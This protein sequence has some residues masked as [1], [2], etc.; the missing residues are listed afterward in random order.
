MI[1]VTINAVDKSDEIDQ[2]SL[3]YQGAVTKDPSTLSFVI[4]KVPGR[5]LPALG[6]VVIASEDGDRFFKGTIVERDDAV[7]SGLLIGTKF[8]CK[9]GIHA[10]DSLLVSKA[11]NDTDAAAVAQDIVDNFA[12]GFTLDAT[13]GSPAVKSIR[14]NYE[15]PSKCLQMLAQQI[16]WDWYI[17]PYDVIHFFPEGAESAPIEVTDDNGKAIYN[18]LSFSSNIVELKNSVYLRG[19]EYLDDVSEANALD[20]YEAD[21]QQVVINIGYKYNSIQ[22]KVAGVAK[23]VGVDNID[24]PAD[25]DCLY[26]FSEKL[27]RFRDDNKPTSGQLV[28]VFGNVYIPLIVQAEDPVSIAQYGRK[29]GIEIDKTI[30]S[31]LEAET[32]STAIL[33]KWSSGSYEGSFKTREKGLRAGQAVKITS[34]SFGVDD[35]FKINTIRGQMSGNDSFE[36]TVLFI[37]SGDYN[38]T[39][40]MVDLLGRDRLNITIS[41]YEVIQRLKKFADDFGMVDEIIAF[42]KTTGPYKYGPVGGGHTIGKYNFSTYS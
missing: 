4:N 6:A 38:F 39:D 18:S 7:V 24:D 1:S 36:Y 3:G 32:A 13:A 12:S 29:E 9:D 23:T 27:I 5:S 14:F 10:F 21:G 16:G 15:Q 19:G 31:V 17:D 41:E 20:K 34:A 37:K 8:T 28:K 42:T 26:N 33:D 25:F 11:Y 35:T 40:I 22:V 30:T 2:D